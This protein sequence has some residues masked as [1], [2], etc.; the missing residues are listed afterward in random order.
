MIWTRRR[1]LRTSGSALAG[2]SLSTLRAPTLLGQSKT[3][4]TTGAILS[5]T[6]A[7][8]VTGKL[9][10]DG[11]QVA[12]QAINDAGGIANRFTIDLV[13]EDTRTSQTD[14]VNAANR[15]A[16]RGDVSFAMGPIISSFGLAV[17]PILSA[18]NIPHIY[19]GAPR[20]FTDLHNLFPLSVRYGSQTALQAAPLLKWAVEERGQ[21]RIFL[22]VP[23]TD[24]GQAFQAAVR[25]QLRELDAGQLI[26]TEFYPPFNRDF[27]TI[28]SKIR[29]AGATAMM[30]GTG[31]PAEVIAAAQEFERQGIDPN[32]LGFYTG[33]TPNGSVQ[34]WEAVSNSGAADGFIHTWLY[35]S[36]EMPRDFDGNVP[37]LERAA[38][39]EQAFQDV[40]GRP[41]ESGQVEAW[42]WGG[43][44][45]IKQAIEQLVEQEGE[46]TVA[47]MDPVQELPRAVVD[48]LLPG[49]GA[50]GAGPAFGTPFGDVG[51]LPCAQYNTR[52]GVAT[53]R[54]GG[55]QHLLTPRGYGDELIGPLCG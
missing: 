33:Q 20:D 3:A 46:Q 40:L 13:I 24:R 34:F 36:P 48:T 12:T 25:G 15:L 19:F 9:Q 35:A 26:G 38:E 6:G 32:Q 37:S 42:G 55:E 29:N 4:L 18:A 22:A 41:P 5:V 50:D 23:N 30:L 21:D 47:A 53:F 45:L 28:V 16:S 43:I 11:A 27:S 17:Q 2:L 14:A 1:F 49:Q 54:N 7:N 44:Q 10:R 8:A 39:M 31:V 51:F 52:L